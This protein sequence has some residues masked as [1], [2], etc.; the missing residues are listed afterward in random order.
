MNQ[1]DNGFLKSFTGKVFTQEGIPKLLTA[2][3]IRP[4]IGAFGRGWG[5]STE[6]D[7]RVG[8]RRQ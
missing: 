6:Q 7:Q 3:D 8:R 4:E 1:Q 5:S 2:E